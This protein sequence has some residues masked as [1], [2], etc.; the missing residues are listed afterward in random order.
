MGHGKDKDLS[1]KP[2]VS[3]KIALDCL[4]ILLLPVL[5]A[6]MLVGETAHEYLGILMMLCFSA[7]IFL[8]RKW[9]R[10][11]FRGRYSPSRIFQTGINGLLIVMMLG[12]MISGI[13]LSK[14]AF[15]FLNIQEGMAFARILHMLTA[16]WGFVLMS[17]HLGLH[18]EMFLGMIRNRT[19]VSASG[20][21]KILLK[22]PAA[23]VVLYGLY[24]LVKTDLLSH[25]FLKNTFIFFDF[26]RPL[27][28][29]FS[30]YLAMM[31]MWAV[32]GHYLS[33][34]LRKKS[35]LNKK[36]L[37]SLLQHNLIIFP[38]SYE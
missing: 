34:A 32:A 18:G 11:L 9:Y 30:D 14:H 4:M 25:M 5:M 7:H 13:I 20:L 24:T 10:S 22:I 17:L 37:R 16:Y 23:A 26:E 2:I 21:Q 35:R 19:K 3:I 38:E 36:I 31:G 12:M 27:F 29:F 28:L 6:Y 15:V 1:M 33:G 8:N